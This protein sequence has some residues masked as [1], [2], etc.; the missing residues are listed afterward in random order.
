MFPQNS[1]KHESTNTMHLIQ[2]IFSK[3]SDQFDLTK[4][5]YDLK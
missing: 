4:Q 2:N 5:E 1:P 3:N